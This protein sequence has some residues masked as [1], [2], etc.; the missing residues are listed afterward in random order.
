MRRIT[1]S[2]LMIVS[3]S[4]ANSTRLSYE[5]RSSPRVDH[6]T[7]AEWDELSRG[8]TKDDVRLLLGEP[9][10]IIEEAVSVS[11][12][13]WCYAPYGYVTFSD[14]KVIRWRRPSWDSAARYAPARR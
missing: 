4:C 9:Y 14:G 2:L 5:D 8:M 7:V 6:S 1:F 12:E 13:F 11:G 10:R 3:V